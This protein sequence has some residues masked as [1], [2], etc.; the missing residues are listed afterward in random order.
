MMKEAKAPA[1]HAFTRSVLEFRDV[2]RIYQ[3]YSDESQKEKLIFFI[4]I[5]V[6]VKER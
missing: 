5:E 4:I 6:T 2:H 3:P 1:F